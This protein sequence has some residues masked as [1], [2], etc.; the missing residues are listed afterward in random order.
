MTESKHKHVSELL[1][2]ISRGDQ[3]AADALFPMLHD[4]FLALARKFMS[5]ERVDHTIEPTALVNEAYL[6]LVD[7]READWRSKSHFMAIGAKAMRRVLVDHARSKGRAKR[8]GGMERIELRED[9]ALSPG[10]YEDVLAVD[11]A[12]EKL[13]ALDERQA[14]L[15]ELRFFGCLGMNEVAEA[16]GV[17]LRTVESDWTMVRAWLR[18]ELGEDRAPRT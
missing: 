10:R 4:E 3:K 18:N 13:S 17:S 5:R 6:R 9:L 12:I 11:E 16:L 2:K 8:G 1:K 14:K 15:V 7:Q